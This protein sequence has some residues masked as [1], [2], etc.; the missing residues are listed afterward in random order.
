MKTGLIIFLV[1]LL[2]H[3][4]LHSYMEAQH[5]KVLDECYQS[6]IEM[7]Q[8]LRQKYEPIPDDAE[9]LVWIKKSSGGWDC[10][11]RTGQG[12]TLGFYSADKTLEGIL[13]E[14]LKNVKEGI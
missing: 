13:E 5:N 14:V 10:N 7:Y 2:S 11:F 9:T 6:V 1:V 8:K 4:L 3:A 12:D